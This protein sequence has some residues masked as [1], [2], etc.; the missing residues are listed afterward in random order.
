MSADDLRQRMSRWG[1]PEVAERLGPDHRCK[2]DEF[3]CPRCAARDADALEA[4]TDPS[5]IP[6]SVRMMPEARA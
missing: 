1:D 3:P 6:L 4:A 5:V 2:P